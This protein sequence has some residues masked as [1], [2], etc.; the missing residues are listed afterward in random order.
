MA[1]LGSASRFLSRACCQRG[2]G[3][4]LC[5]EGFFRQRS[6]ASLPRPLWQ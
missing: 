4:G 1:N 5:Q 2:H 6:L 3:E